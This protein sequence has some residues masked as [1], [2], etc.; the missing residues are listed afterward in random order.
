MP[1]SRQQQ[2]LI[3]LI[4][5]LV[6]SALVTWLLGQLEFFQGLERRTLDYRYR[7]LGTQGVASDRIA[8]VKIDDFALQ[9][10]EPVFGRWPLPREV[11]AYFLSFMQRAG[12]R[13]VA[14]DVLFTERER[15]EGDGLTASDARLVEATWEAGMVI[16]AVNLG[17]QQDTPAPDPALLESIS[18]SGNPGFRE[19]VQANAPFSR[20]AEASAGLGHVGIALDPD[21]P[22]RRYLVMAGYDDRSIPSLGLISSLVARGKEVSDISVEDQEIQA[23]GMRI[24]LDEDWRLPIWFNG[25]P[26]T[27]STY[28]YYQVVYS[29]LQ[30]QSGEEPNIDPA[31][32]EDRIVLVGVTAAGLHDLFTTPYSGGAADSG[33]EDSGLGKMA[34][35]EIHANL[36]DN[37]LHGRFLRPVPPLA[38]GLILLVL[39]ACVAGS[40]LYFR[41]T[42]AGTIVAGLLALYLLSAQA[43]F[44]YRYQAPVAPAVLLWAVC[45]GL[46]LGYQ[47]WIED[48]EK[49][50]VKKIFSRYVSPDI[51]QQLLD[52]PSA[53]NLGGQRREMTVLFSDL[54]GFTSLSEDRPPEE[55]VSQLNEY[56]SEMVRVVFKNKGT[57]DKFVG[58]MIMA[59]FGAPLGDE[60][61]ADH[62]V[63]CA[64][65]MHLRLQELNGRWREQGWPEL[66]HGV[67]VN[68]GE[69]IAGNVGAETIQSYTVIGDNVNLGAR[70]ESLCKEYSAGIIIS[71]FTRASLHQSFPLKPLGEVVVRGKS[72]PV[73]IFEVPV[74]GFSS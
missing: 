14:F 60:E 62:A 72:R 57:I 13:L 22:V 34:G 35:V 39:G 51:F 67:G 64:V 71:D 31:Q 8:V 12:A 19:F 3:A 48:A 33:A 17:N 59:L 74:D 38:G 61:H 49:R 42:V 27:Y 46:A 41:L 28:G 10:M 25:G 24:P 69:M 65:E 54:R 43:V 11:H 16:H 45:L 36:I 18:I 1:R 29:E 47:Y 9:S 26:G 58:D 55:I 63:Q 7:L 23:G 37:L 15:T 44:V 50:K 66:Q 2:R 30:I 70:L 40:I 6:I 20:L 73:E 5:I 21:G 68:S 4:G 53:T 52:D 32:F 56:F